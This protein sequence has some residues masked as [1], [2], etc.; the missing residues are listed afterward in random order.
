LER[1]D[2]ERGEAPVACV[3]LTDFLDHEAEA[4][5]RIRVGEPLLDDGLA[6]AHLV[7]EGLGDQHL[8]G[9]KAAVQGGGANPGAPGDLPHRRVQ[10]LGGEHRAG[11]VEDAVAVVP[12][13]WAQGVRQT[14]GHRS[15]FS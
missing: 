1:L 10:A 13:I 6:R 8:L 11:R 14:V 9:R 3:Q 5:P 4:V 7:R 15:H 12:G 2:R